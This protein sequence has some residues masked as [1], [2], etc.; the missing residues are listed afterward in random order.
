MSVLF[1]QVTCLVVNALEL[2]HFKD[3]VSAVVTHKITQRE[4]C[5]HHEALLFLKSLISSSRILQL[6]SSLGLHLTAN[7]G[8]FVKCS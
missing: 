2:I 7:I 1:P 5:A 4:E 8:Q 6:S 3:L